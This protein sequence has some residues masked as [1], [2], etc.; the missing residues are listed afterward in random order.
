MLADDLIELT[1][2]PHPAG[3][4]G[5]DGAGDRASGDAAQR[6]ALYPRGEFDGI[7]TRPILGAWR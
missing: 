3:A 4:V 5:P 7:N 2:H 1:R 6:E